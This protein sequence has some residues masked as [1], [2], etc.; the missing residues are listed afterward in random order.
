MPQ[1]YDDQPSRMPTSAR[2]YVTQKTTNV[3]P[4]D[5]LT[6]ALSRVPRRTTP[7]NPATMDQA[8]RSSRINATTT[9]QQAQQTRRRTGDDPAIQQANLQKRMTRRNLFNLAAY[10]VSTAVSGIALFQVSKSAWD[11]NQ[12]DAEVGKSSASERYLVCGHHDSRQSPT[13]LFAYVRKTPDG[14]Y[15][16]VFFQ[17]YPGGSTAKMRTFQ[18]DDLRPHFEPSELGRIH[19]EMDP[20]PADGGKYQILLTLTL[21]PKHI[22]ATPQVVHFLFVDRKRDYFEPV[23]PAAK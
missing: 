17:E 1:Y 14:L 19:L 4:H 3:D 10:G 20:M 9:T 15:S 11:Q 5:R 21:S 8:R 6:E 18:S 2:R 12:Q 23:E 16:S 7:P 13:F 22:F